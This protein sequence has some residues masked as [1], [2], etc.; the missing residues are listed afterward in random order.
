[1]C[2][3]VCGGLRL[4]GFWDSGHLG[5]LRGSLGVGRRWVAP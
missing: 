5:A 2:V 4:P 3:C 1:M